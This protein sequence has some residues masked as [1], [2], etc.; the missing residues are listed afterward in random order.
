MRVLKERK[1]IL[2]FFELLWSLFKS[3]YRES[4]F[5]L[6]GI[7]GKWRKNR[8]YFQAHHASKAF[9]NFSNVELETIFFSS[10]CVWKRAIIRVKAQRRLF[11]LLHGHPSSKF[12]VHDFIAAIHKGRAWVSLDCSTLY[13][14]TNDTNSGKKENRT[15]SFSLLIENHWYCIHKIHEHLKQ[16]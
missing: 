9:L 7:D 2:N 10:I 16:F 12:H 14:K 1:S 8:E 13:H 5:L 3:F 4:L 6:E 15:L 11:I